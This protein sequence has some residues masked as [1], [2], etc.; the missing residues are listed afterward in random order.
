MFG[1]SRYSRLLL[2]K[3]YR[4]RSTRVPTTANSASVTSYNVENM[5]PRSRHIPRIAEHIADYLQTPD[6]MFVQ[7]IQD[8]SGP[9]NNGVVSANKTL[10]ALVDAIEK[11]SSSVKYHFVNI[12]PEDN[13]DGGAP[14]GNIR[15]A[16][17]R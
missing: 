3:S 2:R 8:D 13:K 16:Y 14:G 17:L 4:Q 11:A 9:R 6:I 5:S 7:E 12:D 10:Q 1:P 15:V